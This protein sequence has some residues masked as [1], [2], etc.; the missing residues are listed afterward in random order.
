MTFADGTVLVNPA[1]CDEIIQATGAAMQI[2][3]AV[4]AQKK[5]AGEKVFD[6]EDRIRTTEL[7]AL[8]AASS[9]D[10]RLD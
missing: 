4:E 2:Y 5:A 8:P 7:A 9:F 3:E 10:P 1:T 6:A